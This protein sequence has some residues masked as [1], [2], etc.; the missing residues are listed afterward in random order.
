[1]IEELNKIYCMDCLEGFKQMKNNSVD[2]I[3]TDPPYILSSGGT[4]DSMFKDSIEKLRTGLD[5]MNKGFDIKKIFSECKRVTKKFNMFCF[6]SNKQISSIM[7][8][9][10]DNN[11]ITTLLVWWKYNI[12]PFCNGV[13]KGDIKY[14]VHIREKGATFQGN[15]KLK[16]KVIKLPMEQSSYGHP[17]I[18]PL[19]IIR[20][21]I[22]IG[23]NEGDVVLDPFIGSGTT[24]VACKELGRD[25]I[26]FELEQRYVDIANKRLSIENSKTSLWEFDINV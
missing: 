12:I 2:L 16:T 13:S 1:M 23:S 9:G 14:I 18:K 3:V 24:A 6:C 7:K 22:K 15:A 10:E 4:G 25:F 8:W 11:Y 26:G 20:K 17:T 19:D 5:G 21:F